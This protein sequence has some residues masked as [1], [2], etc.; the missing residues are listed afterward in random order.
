MLV[1]LGLV[2]QRHKGVLEVFDGSSVV[3][4]AR[5]YGVSRQSFHAWLRRYRP[6]R[7]R[8]SQVHKAWR[9]IHQLDSA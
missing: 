4:V 7:P 9:R 6:P 8:R 1:E 5:R 3:D 2:K